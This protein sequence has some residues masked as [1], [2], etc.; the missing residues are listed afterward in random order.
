MLTI[1]PTG[2]LCNRMRALDAAIALSKD[3]GQSL[4]VKWVRNKGLNARF[5]DLFQPITELPVQVVET[6]TS[7]ITRSKWYKK[8]EAAKYDIM[9]DH[10]ECKRLS[11]AGFDFT[12]LGKYQRPFISGFLPFYENPD[13]F[14]AFVPVE[15]IEAL[16]SEETKRF[17]ERVVGV[18]VRRSDHEDAIRQSPLEAFIDAME[19]EIESDPA[20]RFY[21]ASDDSGVKQEMKARFGER[22]MTNEQ[23][24][25]R[26]DLQGI[27][28]A[29]VELF[30]L[31]R[32]HKLIGSF[33][34]SFSRTAAHLGKIEELVIRCD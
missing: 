25:S 5:S 32:T 30:A 11:K 12:E 24:A 28:G 34:S 10:D 31:S 29:V 16:I 18:H 17:S 8:R 27:C 26:S 2:G 33:R 7:A 19:K 21:L 9:I 13:R 23:Q 6:K 4:E 1:E 14:S 3:L 15:S 22:L 20:T